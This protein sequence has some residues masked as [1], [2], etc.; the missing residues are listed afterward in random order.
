MTELDDAKDDAARIVK[1]NIFGIHF[2]YTEQPSVDN[3]YPEV[4]IRVAPFI[5]GAGN[6]KT[7]EDIQDQIMETELFDS[8]RKEYLSEENRLLYVGM[9]R[10]R[11]VLILAMLSNLGTKRSPLQWFKDVRLDCINPDAEEDILG[12]GYKF[13]NATLKGSESAM[14]ERY[15]Y[16]TDRKKMNERRIPYIK[17]LC[18]VEQ[19][20]VSPSS[21]KEKWC[22]VY[23]RNLCERMPLG[24]S[25]GI[26]MDVA[27]NCIHQ[28][29]CG[30]E[31]HVDDESYI[32]S[33][34]KNYGMDKYLIKPAAI[35]EAWDALV[36]Y[37][38]EQYGLAKKVY[39]ERPFTLASDGRIYTGSID[40]VWQ[41]DEGNVVIDFK[42][43]PMGDE[44]LLNEESDF[45]AGKYG[46]QLKTYGMALETAGETV[47]ARYIYYPISG[48][49][50][51]IDDPAWYPNTTEEAFAILDKMLSE[52]E[53]KEALKVKD[54]REWAI[55]Q[56]FGLGLWVRNMWIYKSN[57]P[58][59]VLTG[60][61][62]VAINEGEE[63]SIDK[64][65][66]P[67]IPDNIS[68]DF[69]TLYHRHLRELKEKV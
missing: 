68:T 29:F 30:I 60:E 66:T 2:C 36:Q 16:M 34:I 22:V 39:H 46:G 28:I 10:P 54:D 52:E 58:D 23:D 64:L 19:K 25:T 44:A 45:Y 6:S 8:A 55:Y 69:L 53:K 12:V 48:M 51:E 62:P 43:N 5:Y 31:Q 4:Y 26:E 27:G 57:V 7:P 50:C 42:S 20:F 13:E 21:I 9:T 18:D 24:P 14:L 63:I 59:Y 67:D 1:R 61:E 33:L 40:L 3:P 17:D 32:T 49:I 65:L 47:L 37:L 56:H 15:F 35:K 11:D 41:T 38:T